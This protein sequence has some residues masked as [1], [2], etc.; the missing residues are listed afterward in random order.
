MPSA[1]ISDAIGQVCTLSQARKTSLT[2]AKIS[3]PPVMFPT[4][5]D[6]ETRM[7]DSIHGSLSI[8]LQE[9]R[10]LASAV[11]WRR[12]VKGGA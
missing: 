5:F 10:A 7:G 1:G 9:F 2:I 6:E 4:D 3:A 8:L 12:T 11:I